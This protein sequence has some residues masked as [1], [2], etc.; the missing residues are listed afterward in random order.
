MLYLP[1]GLQCSYN[2]NAKDLYELILNE[3]Q[4]ILS[5]KKKRM[6]KNIYGIDER[7]GCKKIDMYCQSYVEEKYKNDGLKADEMGY[8]REYMG[9]ESRNLGHKNDIVELM[10]W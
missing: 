1:N 2:K 8:N 5:L 9:M 4:C 10:E 6:Q 3:P 7:K